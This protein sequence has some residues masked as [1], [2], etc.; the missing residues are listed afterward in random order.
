M[1]NC[2]LEDSA[3]T[4]TAVHELRE[5]LGL[6]VVL[7]P[8]RRNTKKPLLKGW[9]TLT[10]AAME[11]P[12][13]LAQ[14][15]R[16]NIGVSLGHASNGL[17]TVDL[18]NDDVVAP[19]LAVNPRL[20]D[21]TRTARKRGCNLWVRIEGEFPKSRKLPYGE[22]RSD[23]NQTVIFGSAE[24]IPYRFLKRVP[25]VR[26]PYAD[27]VFPNYHPQKS[28]TTS[29]TLSPLSPLSPSATPL[30]CKVARVTDVDSA[31]ELALPDTEHRN[32][33]ALFL[34][35]RAVKTLEA[36]GVI[37]GKPAR[38]AVFDRWYELAK[39]R[40]IL[41]ADQSRDGYLLQ[42]FNAYR[43]ARHLLIN[44]VVVQAWKLAQTEP[45]P[46]ESA[47]FE[48]DAAKRFVALCY[49]MH[50]LANGGEWF[51]PTRTVARLL[52]V[53]HTLAATWFG[54]LLAL[55]VLRLTQA[56]TTKLATRYQ[57]QPEAE[58]VTARI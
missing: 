26:M 44:A 49:Q 21:T 40:G 9:P 27:L 18:D 20:K 28:S 50:L 29:A 57:Y 23:G 47:I 14:L 1:R 56:H 19:F 38:I 45:F 48:T 16:G 5:L 31:L 51:I 2:I 6:D 54:G 33:A 7:I 58:P 42:F 4:E 10:A 55:D 36:Q 53:S 11:D 25:P 12:D 43:C 39:E 13:H 41:R 32:N 35:A 37:A 17:V 34:F 22:F 8:V 24:G 30:L 15:G 46:P 3:S 52:G